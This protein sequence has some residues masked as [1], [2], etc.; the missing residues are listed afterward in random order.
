VSELEVVSLPNG[1]FV[2]NCYL[3]ADRRTNEAVIIDPGE[4]HQ[5][6]LA[7]LGARNW[8]L[9]EI[10]LTHGHIDHIMGVEAVHAETRAPISL[11]V[12]TPSIVR[13]T[14]RCR[15]TERGWDSSSIA[16]LP[17]T[18]SWGR[19][20]LSASADS[21]SRCGLPRGTRPGAS[22]FSGRA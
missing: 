9:R 17:H 11:H 22:A 5:L 10:W 2:E 16:R 8:Q 6:F 20:R 18:G 7:E 3:V 15:S 19:G 13:F 12:S 21:S 1:Q 4:D 14:M